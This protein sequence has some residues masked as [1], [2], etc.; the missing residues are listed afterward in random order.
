MSHWSQIK[1]AWKRLMENPQARDIIASPITKIL[2]L[3]TGFFV[4]LSLTQL[5]WRLKGVSESLLVKHLSFD[6]FNIREHRYY[7]MLTYSFSH[8]GFFHYCKYRIT[9]CLT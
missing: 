5:L 8:F 9:Q 2:A 6:R 4:H 1:Q 3:N 7:T